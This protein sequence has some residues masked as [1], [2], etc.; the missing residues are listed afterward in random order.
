MLERLDID[1]DRE[2]NVEHNEDLTSEIEKWSNFYR[3]FLLLSS[4]ESLFRP[5]TRVR[6][7]Q[8]RQRLPAQ[9]DSNQQQYRSIL[10]LC[11]YR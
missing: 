8:R 10:A 2:E 9:N 3:H 1:N 4:D 7:C 11:S 6:C 5:R